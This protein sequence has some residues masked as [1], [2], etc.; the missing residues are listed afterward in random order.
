MARFRDYFDR[1]RSRGDVKRMPR[2]R[3]PPLWV[4]DNAE[5]WKQLS[6]AGT[7]SVP[8]LSSQAVRHRPPAR[9]SDLSLQRELEKSWN[10]QH[11][12]VFSKDNQIVQKNYRSYFD[13]WKD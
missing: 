4:L 2:P 10:N 5:Y 1:P 11:H 7:H 3:L 9:T 12:V 13:R 6:A 8:D